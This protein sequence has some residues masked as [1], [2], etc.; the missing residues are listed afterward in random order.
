MSESSRSN[1]LLG[2]RR[3]P[4]AAVWVLLGSACWPVFAADSAPPQ[5]PTVGV[6]APPDVA[7][8]APQVPQITQDALLEARAKTAQPRVILDVRTE[9][10]Y[11]AGHVPGAVNIPHDQLAKRVSELEAQRDSEIVVYCRSGR[12]SNTALHTLRAAGFP[13]LAHLEGDFAAW[14]G[15]GRPVEKAAV[16]AEAPVSEPPKKP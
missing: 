2:Q 4:M 15:A 12:R 10:E 7:P 8:V 13:K 14:E 16:A 1:N 9:A 11:A 3:M 6:P 5:T